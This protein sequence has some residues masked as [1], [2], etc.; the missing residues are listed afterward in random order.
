MKGEE[1]NKKIKVLMLVTSFAPDSIIAAVRPSMFARYLSKDKFDIT[2]VRSG[3]IDG[4][5]DDSLWQY[6]KHPKC[7]LF[8]I[9]IL[10]SRS[11]RHVPA[12]SK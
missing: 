8:T 9:L 11:I 10:H 3:R 2:I 1:Q 5:A 6:V 7:E 12:S 4:K